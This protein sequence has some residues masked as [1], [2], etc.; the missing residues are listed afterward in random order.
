MPNA[1]ETTDPFTSNR[2]AEAPHGTV[3]AQSRRRDV[4]P[5]TRVRFAIYHLS[6][7]RRHPTRPVGPEW[8]VERIGDC[9]SRCTPG[10]LFQRGEGA[11]MVDDVVSNR[12]TSSTIAGEL[13]AA[14]H[15]YGI[16]DTNGV[17]RHSAG[18]TADDHIANHQIYSTIPLGRVGHEFSRNRGC[19]ARQM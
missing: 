12:V 18:L 17:M 3:H 13:S 9:T 11:L 15:L 8:Q 14:R 1:Q 5:G 4:H 16:G 19:S 7:Q 10:I 2:R 6:V